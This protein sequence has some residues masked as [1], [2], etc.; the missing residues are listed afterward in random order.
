[1][2]SFIILFIV[3]FS[4]AVQAETMYISDIIEIMIRTGPG[5]DNRI[6][7]MIKSG[8]KV[9]MLKPGE[10]WSLVR[11]ANGKE[12]WAL[13]RFLTSK[14][15]DELALARLG[16][17]YKVLKNQAVSLIE[18]NKVYKKENKQL[19]SELKTNKKI[20]NKIKLSYETLKKESAEFLELKSNYKKTAS[21][22]AEQ[23]KKAE[24]LEDKLTK[25]LLHRN[26][27]WFLSG[28]GV[29]LLGF[30]IGFSASRQRKRSSLL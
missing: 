24:K 1:M 14:E 20:L 19:N 6:M 4:T 30:V 11:I 27:K 22:L 23:T 21:I 18:E 25:L 13:N 12:G 17:K 5:S 15:P 26:I 29:L 28:A 16:E 2:K 7:A 9:E 3:L 8:E 10:E